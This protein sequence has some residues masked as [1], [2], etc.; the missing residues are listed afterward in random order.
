MATRS[1]AGEYVVV[2]CLFSPGTLLCLGALLLP[3]DPRHGNA[4]LFLAGLFFLAVAGGLMLLQ[5]LLPKPREPEPTS[6]TTDRAP[7]G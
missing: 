3:A 7:E 1:R 5:Q 2:G 6:P 4:L